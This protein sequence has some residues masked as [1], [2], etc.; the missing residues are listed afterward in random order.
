M[1]E[2]GHIAPLLPLLCLYLPALVCTPHAHLYPLC[3]PRACLMLIR[4][5]RTCS[6]LPHLFI[7]PMLASCS[8]ILPHAHLYPHCC[9]CSYCRHCHC[10]SCY[11]WCHGGHRSCYHCCCCCC[12][13]CY[14]CCCHCRCGCCSCSACACHHQPHWAWAIDVSLLIVVIVYLCYWLLQLVYL[15]HMNYSPLFLILKWSNTMKW[16]VYIV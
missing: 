8:F 9:C 6:Y 4:A 10:C 5:L 1:R 14:C 7:P 13:G 3:L 15:N 11:W 16:L 12:F 2:K